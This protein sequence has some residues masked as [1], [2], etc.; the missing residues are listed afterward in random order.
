MDESKRK[1]LGAGA[2]ILGAGAVA[3]ASAGAGKR[4][5]DGLI[6]GTAGEPVRDGLNKNSLPPEFSVGQSGEVRLTEGSRVAFNHCWGCCSM[7]GVRLH[8]D[9][10]RD[11]VVRVAGNPYN[12]LSSSHAVP[13]D[14]PVRE[15]LRGLSA[16]GE[17]PE[18]ANAGHAGRSTV[19][20]RGAAM[21]DASDNPFRIT[22]CLKRVG[23]RGEGR[24]KSIPFEQLVEEVVEGGDLF[25]EGHVDG[26]RAIRE[27]PGP[28]N[29]E[30]PEFGPHSNR[31]LLTYALDDGRE[32]LFFQRFGM[33][34]YG[35]R[36]FGKHGAYCGLTYRM[37]SGLVMDDLA[38][39]AHTKPDFENCEFGLFWGTAPGQAGN[40][41]KHSARMVAEARVNGPMR[42]AVIDPV[43][44]LS[45]TDAVRDKVRWVPVRPDMD[46]ALTMGMIRWILE[47]ER[48]DAGFLSRPTLE[49]AT[50]AGEA[51]YSNATH[52][53]CMTGHQAGR[54]LRT[55][56]G[57]GRGGPGGPGGPGVAP[58]P[59]E[60][61]VMTPQG[62][63]RPASR[64]SEAMLFYRG[65]A[66]LPD[67]TAVTAATALQ[68]LREEALSHD[69]DE[70]A[71]LCGVPRE[72]IIDLAREF[73]SH[74]K[75]AA[76]DAHGGMMGATGMNA[77]FAVL[78]LNTLIG[79]LNVKGGIS[80]SGGNFHSPSLKG[81]RYDLSG[82]P[83][84]RDPKGFPA[85]RCRAPYEKSAAYKK[86]VE[87]GQSPYPAD[88]PWFPLTAPNLPAEHLL[89]HANGYP[90]TF[91][92][93]INW[94]G[95]VIYGH[96]GLKQALDEKLKDPTDL[97]L[98][99]GI[100]AFHNETNAYAD[101]LV[102]DPCLYEVWGG[103]AE[104]WSGVLTR[105]ST[106]RW[107]AI[108]PRQQKSAAGQ[109]VCMELFIIEA[110][111]RMGLPGFG[112]KAIPG[113]DGAMH[114]LH[115]PQDYYLRLA[116]NMAFYGDR[117]LPSPTQEDVRLSGIG[118]I[119]PDIAAVLPP[120][121]QGPV[122]Y[123]YS[124][125]G[126][127]DPFSSSYEG[128]FLK[129]RW[130]RAMCIYNEEAATAVH[131][132]TGERY[133]GIPRLRPA[134]FVDGTPLR[135]RWTQKDYPLLMVSFKSN[136]INSY[137]VISPRLRA[138]KPVNMVL[139][140][141]D[142]ARALGV[143]NGDRVRLVS[144]G[145][146]REAQV[147]VSDTIMPGVVGVEHGFGHTALGAGDMIVD[148]VRIPAAAGAGA[149]VNLNDLVPADPSRQGFSTLTECDTGSAV[150]QGIPVRVEK[151][152]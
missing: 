99:I 43:L 105:M 131:S 118:R 2:A 100:D 77:T 67:G 33:Q 123:M 89:G 95:N 24:W 143:A 149:G 122:A 19:C 1:L 103:F 84:K 6:R 44:R 121:E 82:F 104:A 46:V 107:P 109:P 71:S 98:F 36:N 106:A 91:K 9:E 137:A 120:E 69:L 110:A 83:G 87:S 78:T 101:Y 30:C 51:A 23:R 3:A 150:R 7:C 45:I 49:A 39:N 102:P 113:A 146:S 70:Y 108:E 32:N 25:G 128:D 73:T 132:Q 135:S 129:S 85:N 59:G 27:T 47:N 127:Y 148:G 79:N 141:D 142:D 17:A 74:G 20:G 56:P 86:K 88:L 26:L 139:L 96:G 124:R 29:P 61:M 21:I 147:T 136:L 5:I 114:P 42:Y 115:T 126:R 94:T 66:A 80:A 130:T 125:G 138:I 11:K 53:V 92:C 81:P 10:A 55:P 62:E 8:I 40:P 22:R 152:A 60:P 38:A 119:M 134:S 68:L 145:G 12:P 151:L 54:I 52:L 72:T 117:E 4:L 57:D 37:G 15:A 75:R 64:C 144:P 48:Y 34:A 116:A 65:E 35:T 112:D 41:F 13:M 58:D 90:F 18:E 31:L 76:A 28:A 63:P 111:K 16:R 50:A 97:P 133:S 93:W 140:H 14:T